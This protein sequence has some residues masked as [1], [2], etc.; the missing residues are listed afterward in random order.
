MESSQGRVLVV[1]CS[2]YLSTEDIV[3]EV[4]KG[5]IP[6]PVSISDLFN[7]YLWQIENKYYTADIQ[8]CSCCVTSPPKTESKLALNFFFQSIVI[9]FDENEEGL[10]SVVQTSLLRSSFK[11]VNSW[12]SYVKLQD[13][14]ILLLLNSGKGSD[15]VISRAEVVR[16]CLSNSFE[17]INMYIQEEEDSQEENPYLTNPEEDLAGWGCTDAPSNEGSSDDIELPSSL[18]N[19]GDEIESFEELFQRL[20]QMKE[21]ASHLPSKERKSYAE[22]LDMWVIAGFIIVGCLYLCRFE[23]ISAGADLCLPYEVGEVLR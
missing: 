4:F 3:R 23:N 21:Q 17:L 14:S 8:V 19:D 16:W 20:A 5:E 13:P 6:E 10:V 1:S 18:S 12:L 15:L 22:K 7:G 9:A 11:E 2:S